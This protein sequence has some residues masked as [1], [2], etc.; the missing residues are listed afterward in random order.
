[1]SNEYVR[2]DEVLDELSVFSR[3]IQGFRNA[4]ARHNQVRT[5]AVDA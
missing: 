2:T 5:M 3:T 1:M 4:N